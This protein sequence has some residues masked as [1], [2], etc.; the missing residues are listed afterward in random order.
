VQENNIDLSDLTLLQG[1]Y[2]PEPW[3]LVCQRF[4]NHRTGRM[5]AA[6]SMYVLQ[7]TAVALSAL[8][9]LISLHSAE[10]SAWFWAGAI[11]T[12]GIGSISSVGAQGSSLS[13]EKEWTVVLCKG[14]SAVLAKLNSGGLL[15]CVNSDASCTLTGFQLISCQSH[16]M[17]CILA[18]DD[19]LTCAFRCKL[20]EV[21]KF[22]KLSATFA[23]MFLL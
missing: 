14:D 23:G 1:D 10:G 11:C 15:A 9:A 13:V 5:K 12:I 6:C 22:I 2:L 21:A 18:F 17:P 8:C 16:I 3:F 19:E 4:A 7:N 20:K